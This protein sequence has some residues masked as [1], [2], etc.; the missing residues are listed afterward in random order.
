MRRKHT[1]FSRNEFE[2][3]RNLARSYLHV[4]G[5][6]HAICFAVTTKTPF[7]ALTSNAWKIDALVED[8]GIAKWRIVEVASLEDL[9]REPERLAFS[10]EERTRIEAAVEHGVA[11]TAKMFDELAQLAARAGRPAAAAS[12]V[13]GLP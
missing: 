5:R 11:G 7:L 9:V 3:A 6:F 1:L 13:A 8:L 12:R 2:Y 4:S 10:E